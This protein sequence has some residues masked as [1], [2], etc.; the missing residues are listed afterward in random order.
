M[1]RSDT[2]CACYSLALE[3]YPWGLTLQILVTL[4]SFMASGICP[5]NDLV[6]YRSSTGINGSLQDPCI[7]DPL[8]RRPWPG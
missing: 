6:Q 1:R 2:L 5:G 8:P 3:T 7:D 4:A